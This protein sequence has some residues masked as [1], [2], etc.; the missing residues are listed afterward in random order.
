VTYGVPVN[1]L[2]TRVGARYAEQ[3]YRLGREFAELESHGDSKATSLLAGHPFVRR[4][5][6]NL[7]VLA[8]YT[9]LEFTD[10]VDVVNFVSDTTHRVAGLGMAADLQ[11]SLLGGGV[12][13]LQVQ[14]LRGK[15]TLE[16]PQVAAFDA[17]SNGLHVAGDFS[18]WRLRLQRAQALARR[19]SL[20]ATVVVQTASKN[21]DAGPELILGG[22][23]AVRAYPAGE[24][25]ADEGNLARLELRQ[26]F[27]LF[28]D[29][30]TTLSAFGDWA[31]ARINREPLPGDPR[32]TR[33]LAGY[34]VGAHQAVGR[35]LG[36]QLWI[37]W[38]DGP[39]AVSEADRSPRGWFSV[40]WN[41]Q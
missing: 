36:V 28:R 38:R 37:A 1:G 30:Q 12:T 16:T 22:P 34:G 18:T 27:I 41:F 15:V 35:D 26:G 4:T 11:D 32:N 5:D 2:G 33:S 8:S 23:D 20:H 21:L 31:H 7:S 9:H 17:S 14:Y 40:V 10:R 39:P 25:Y 6:R 13:A 29:W 3:R 19:T 24:L